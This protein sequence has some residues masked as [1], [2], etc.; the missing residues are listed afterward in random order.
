MNSS[1]DP[2]SRHSSSHARQAGDSACYSK[3]QFLASLLAAAAC[4]GMPAPTQAQ[5]YPAKTVKIIVPYAPGGGIDVIAR[6]LADQLQRKWGQPVIV[7]NRTGASTIIGTAAVAKATADGHTLLLTSEA[8]IT[9]N[10]FLFNKLPYDPLRDLAPITQLLSLPQMVVA[11]PAIAARSLAE[12]VALAKSRPRSLNYASYGSGSLPHLLFEGLNI[13]SG[14]D[15]VQIQYKGI[16]PAVM[17]ILA[18]EVQ[19]T[20]AGVAAAQAHISAG[21]LKPL[22]VAGNARLPQFPEVPTLREAGFAEIDPRESWFGLFAPS[23]TPGN[24]LEKIQRD[25]AEIGA[26]QEFVKTHLNARGFTPIFSTPA[27]FGKFIREDSEHKSQLIRL[28][29]AKAD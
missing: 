17:A 29:G 24:V 7:E 5:T 6:V 2:V 18:N 16:T 27:A 10:P 20:M 14:I 15:L 12:L 3:R 19:L 28:T 4:V 11:H 13:R 22:A 25:V 9:S 21:N 26:G 8:S 1:S 23:A